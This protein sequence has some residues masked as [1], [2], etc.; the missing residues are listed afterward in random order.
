MVVVGVA[1]GS[2]TL[3]YFVWLVAVDFDCGCV[4][5]VRKVAV[6]GGGVAP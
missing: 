6:V 4:R 1:V 3:Y 5:F 2:W